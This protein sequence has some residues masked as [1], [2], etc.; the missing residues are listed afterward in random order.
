MGLDFGDPGR[1]LDM[2]PPHTA[3]K[4]WKYPTFTAPD[5]R[6]I[7]FLLT[8]KIRKRNELQVRSSRRLSQTAL[9]AQTT[10]I[11][12]TEPSDNEYDPDVVGRSGLGIGDYR[13]SSSASYE[14]TGYAVGIMLQGYYRRLRMAMYVFA[15]WRLAAG[16]IAAI[17]ILKGVRILR[18]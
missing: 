2:L 1:F 5:L 11:A 12:V 10:A 9:D 4:L 3:V 7:V 17:Y 18:R 6:W 15:L 16:S 13:G 14:S 8:Y